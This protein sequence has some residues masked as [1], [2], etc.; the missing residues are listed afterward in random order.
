MVSPEGVI[1]SEWTVTILALIFLG[2]RLYVRIT[3]RQKNLIWSEV[4]LVMGASWLL[5]L[6]ICDTITYRKGAMSEFADQTDVEIKQ[7]RFA[8][9]Y[10]FDAGLYFPKLSMVTI[11]F[12][13]LPRH[14][15]PL[16]WALYFTAVFTAA[17][18][19]IAIFVD[20]F[21]CGLNVPVNW[22]PD[23]AACST[24]SSE[25]VF[26]LNWSFCFISEVLLLALPFPL[27]KTLRTANRHE[28]VSLV[29]LFA[30]GI[31]TIAVS[32]GRFAT[33]MVLVNDIS[34]YVWATTEF[35]VSQIIVSS[36]AL[37]PLMKRIWSSVYSSKNGRSTNGESRRI[38]TAK[39]YTHRTAVRINEQLGTQTDVWGPNDSEV[40]LQAYQK[41]SGSGIQV[42]HSHSV[43]STKGRTDS[44]GSIEQAV[45]TGVTG[46]KP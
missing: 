40:E 26:H 29:F 15:R 18:F 31:I 42:L 5:G 36:M 1:A 13:L 23:P 6:V 10:L 11:Y 3:Q 22:S 39:V 33:M 35:A 19:L 12:Q 28:T 7:L 37:R 8:T 32:A 45:P 30:L 46:P 24:F 25:F 44:D 17:A 2:L 9:N 4:W 14:V 38:S 16:R 21:W 34:I 20:T 41:Q 27:L 43:V